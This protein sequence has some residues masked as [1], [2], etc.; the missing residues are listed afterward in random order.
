[1]N[2][3]LKDVLMM[4]IISVLFGVIYLGCTYAGGILSGVLTPMGLSALGYEPF[5]GIYFMAGAFGV[6]IMRKPGAGIIS[7]MLAAI[8]ECLLGNYFGPIIILS[9]LIQ[10]IGIELLIAFFRYKNFSYPTMIGASVICSVLTLGY[11]LVV[12]GYN[13]IAVPVLLLMLSVRIVSAII[14]T[15]ILTKFICERLAKAGVLRGYAIGKA[16]AL[17]EE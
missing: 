1:M 2:W 7:E 5:Y 3:K 9:G 13:Q 11:N 10:G 8:I 16:F 12:S 6:F 14:F 17:S 4:G 15:G